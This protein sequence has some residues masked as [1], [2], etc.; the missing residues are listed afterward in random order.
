M[1]KRRFQ[2]FVLQLL[3]AGVLRWLLRIVVG[4]N[5]GDGRFLSRESQF[6]LIANHNSHLDALSMMA[7]LPRR[8]LWRVRPVS[9]VDYFGRTKTLAALSN[10]F[11][12]ALLIP[13]EVTRSRNPISIMQG[14]LDDGY[15]LLLFPEGTRNTGDRMGRMKSGIARLIAANPHIPCVPVYLT[16]M[17]K[18]LP[19]GKVMVLP[20]KSS[21][22]F[23]EPLQYDSGDFDAIMTRI[24][25]T[26]AAM[27]L[28]Y[29]PPV[30][31][32]ENE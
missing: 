9:A 25:D 5:L 19:K 1:K 31:E 26:F 10:Y 18:S 24:N 16:G 29:D 6:I 13:R 4:V 11:I 20:Y 32:E 3:Y 27:Q 8:V 23:G 2:S 12:N 28:R 7:S 22:N 21:V 17:R 14:A 15:S 30:D